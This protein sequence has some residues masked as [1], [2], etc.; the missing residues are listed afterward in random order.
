M[1][2][3]KQPVF[4]RFW[5]PVIPVADLGEGPKPF[6]LLGE[7]IVLWLDA[8]GRPAAV[9]DQCCHRT[10]QL[11]LGNVVEGHIRCPYHGWQ[12]DGNGTCVHV[13]QSKDGSISPSYKVPS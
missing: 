5:Y 7:K 11:S 1:L 10:A 6:E 8:E 13:P 2:V 9:R 4:R 3:T 12:F